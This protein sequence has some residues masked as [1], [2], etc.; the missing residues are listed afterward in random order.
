MSDSWV[1]W[2][3]DPRAFPPQTVAEWTRAADEHIDVTPKM[4][5]TDLM[6]AADQE[7]SEELQ[8][9][10]KKQRALEREA[11]KKTRRARRLA[12]LQ[13]QPATSFATVHSDGRFNMKNYPLDTSIE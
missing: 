10:N 5:A 13:K 7:I 9:K 12:A 4:E 2:I 8:R 11:I 1:K 6:A 3:D